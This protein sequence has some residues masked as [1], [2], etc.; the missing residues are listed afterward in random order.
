[1][2]AFN[3]EV[4]RPS[5]AL[6]RVAGLP[7]RS[8]RRLRLPQT[9][10]LGMVKEACAQLDVPVDR[11]WSSVTSAP[12]SPGAGRRSGR[13]ARAHAGHQG[14]RVAAAEQVQTTLGAAVDAALGWSMVS[15]RV[16]LV[17]LDNAGDVLPRGA[18]GACRR[19]IGGLGDPAGRTAR[20]GGCP[21]AARGR[22]G[23][24]V[25]LP[26]DRPEPDAVDPAQ[27]DALVE[28]LRA[29]AFDRAL[30]LTSFHQSPLPTA[31]LLRLA[32][33]GWVG[34]ISDDYPGSL[35]D[36]RHRLPDDLPEPE[37][38]LSLARAAGSSCPTETTAGCRCVS[39]CRRERPGAGAAVR[40]GPPRHLGPGARLARRPARR[41][42][43]AA[44][45]LGDG[46]GRHR[47]RVPRRPHRAG[48]SSPPAAPTS[49]AHRPWRTSPR[50]LLWCP[51]RWWAGYHRAPLPRLPPSGRRWGRSVR[52]HR[53]GHPLGAR[54][55]GR[56]GVLGDQQA[57]VP[58]HAGPPPALCPGHPCLHLG[59][60]RG[61]WVAARAAAG[62]KRPSYD[63]GYDELEVAR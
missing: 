3:A 43:A 23:R 25:A 7:P 4:D 31:L 55:G 42:V 41:G 56:D 1:M 37:R 35:L 16:L 2:Q 13:A 18:G 63:G 14:R 49:W 10:G 58:Q 36:L 62:R 24:D 52:A 45:R 38:A 30:V 34:A 60:R 9:R 39:R 5:R 54:N 51:S 6:R 11:A 50:A 61:T 40:R 15:G 48:P 8:Q 44:V 19:G 12:S 57:S 20:H 28:K 47:V 32:G 26:M 27:I 53:P 59:H 46:R 29:E 17:R 22:R 33:V 21:A